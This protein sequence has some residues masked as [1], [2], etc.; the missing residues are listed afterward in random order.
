MKIS[1]IETA[2]LR[3]PC[4][5]PMSLELTDHRMVAAFIASP[6]DRAMAWA[7]RPTR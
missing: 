5:R 3:V 1:G 7:S 4:P 2:V 6:S